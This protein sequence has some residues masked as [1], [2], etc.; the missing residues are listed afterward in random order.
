MERV[1]AESNTRI[2]GMTAKLA[3]QCAQNALIQESMEKSLQAMKDSLTQSELD[4][5][6][7]LE[8]YK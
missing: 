2:E 6:E 7:N 1:T 5:A 8:E 3:E 4:C